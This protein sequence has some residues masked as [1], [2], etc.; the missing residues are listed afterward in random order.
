MRKSIHDTISVEGYQINS[1]IRG[2]IWAL[3]VTIILGV[4]ISLLLQY[5]SLSEN[6][7]SSYSTFIFFISMLIGSTIGARAAGSKGL[8]HGL[9]I[10]LFY[11]VLTLFIGLI[12]N[13]GALTLIF[14]AK[15]LGFTVTAGILGGIIGIGLAEK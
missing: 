15:R 2:L 1:V 3:V 10:T 8:V 13:P 7:L 5:T 12:W 6:L 9:S 11:W 4:L 14:L